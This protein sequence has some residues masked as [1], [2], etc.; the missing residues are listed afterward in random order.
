MKSN[1]VLVVWPEEEYVMLVHTKI[2]KR[3]AYLVEIF[4][5]LQNNSEY[6]FKVIDCIES[7]SSHGEVLKEIA[8]GDYFCV[9]LVS[10]F[11]TARSLIKLSQWI[12]E[13]DP[14]IKVLAYGD[15]IAIVP[16]FFK[17]ESKVDAILMCGDWEIAILDYINYIAGKIEINQVRG[18]EI[19]E[20]NRW[21]PYKKGAYLIGN[22]WS[23]PDM[24]SRV[25]NSGLYLD[26]TEG[27]VT[28]SVSR[29]CPFNCKFC[30]AV[31]TFGIKDRRKDIEEVIHY[32]KNYKNRVKSFKF[33]SPTFTFDE[34]WVK[35]FCKRLILSGN[36][37]PW[38]ATT[39]PDQVRDEEMVKLMAESGCYKI[40]IGVETMDAKS[41]N[42]LNK[43]GHNH[44]KNV[45]TS[46]GL[47]RRYNIL[48]RA[49]M[50]IGIKGQSAENIKYTYSELESFGASVRAAAYSPRE[51]LKELDKDNKVTIDRIEELD[52]MTFYDNNIAGVDRHKFLN[53]I[54]NVKNYNKIL[55]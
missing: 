38:C 51:T 30:T 5:Y 22:S 25:F 2:P 31:S 16:N 49:L 55:N 19:F 32:I 28:M 3:W 23:F 47:L 39:R 11:E 21:I 36:V 33:F 7:K 34:E 27:E 29:G 1:K 18:V 46:I 48:V 41:A 24:S 20:N 15:L 44:H 26:I 52:K 8:T 40:A 10:R 54:Y 35:Q 45:R 9:I 14:R 4:S 17:R 53:L 37:V 42:E 50:M 6:E 43:F 13:I 12:K